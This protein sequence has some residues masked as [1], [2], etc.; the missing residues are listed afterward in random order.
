[1]IEHNHPSV[2]ENTKTRNKWEKEHPEWKWDANLSE[3]QKKK[4]KKWSGGKLK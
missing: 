3:E 2:T 4:V 1:M